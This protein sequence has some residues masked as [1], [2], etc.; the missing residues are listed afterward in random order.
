VQDNL[1]EE[2]KAWRAQLRKGALELAVLLLLRRRR[3]YGLEIVDVLNQ[4][5]KLG[6]SEG[7]IYPLLARL[8]SEGKVEAEWIDDGVGHAHKVYRLTDKGRTVCKAMLAAF[9]EY[10]DSFARLTGE[11]T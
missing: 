9:H 4:E 11:R 8:R 5:I 10:T 1:E 2:I 3:C 6:I 7:S